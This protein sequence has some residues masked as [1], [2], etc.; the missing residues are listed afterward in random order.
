[1]GSISVSWLSP[2][3]ERGAPRALGR[4]R[5]AALGARGLRVAAACWFVVGQPCKGAA[6]PSGR[7]LP[8]ADEALR[9]GRSRLGEGACRTV[10]AGGEGRDHDRDR[11]GRGGGGR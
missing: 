9:R 7:R 11:P 3:R 10:F 8:G 6:R 1:H 5:A 4:G 2:P